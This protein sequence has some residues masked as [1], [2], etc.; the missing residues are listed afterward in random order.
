MMPVVP[1]RSQVTQRSPPE[2]PQDPPR[3]PAASD[4]DGAIDDIETQ[5]VDF[6][7]ILAGSFEMGCTAG[8]TSCDSDEAP[9]QVVTLTYDH[10]IGARPLHEGGEVTGLH[11]GVE[12]EQAGPD[13]PVELLP[14]RGHPASSSLVPS[15]RLTS[16]PGSDD[17]H[18]TRRRWQVLRRAVVNQ[19]RRGV[20]QTRW[21]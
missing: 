4:C 8:Q 11:R 13:E 15:P 9:V 14:F 5:E 17:V 12:G 10:W 3:R 7:A 20:M 16:H 18:P 6:V 21:S 1:R 2:C 19:L